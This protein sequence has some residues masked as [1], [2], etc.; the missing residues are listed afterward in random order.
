MNSLNYTKLGL[1]IIE[2]IIKIMATRSHILMSK[3]TKIDSRRGSTQDPAGE[4][5]SASPS[6]LAE[7][8]GPTSKGRDWRGK[9]RKGG[10]RCRDREEGK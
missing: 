2:I 9:E 10:K 4:A 6:P 5:Y 7:L 1:L 3:N 8:R